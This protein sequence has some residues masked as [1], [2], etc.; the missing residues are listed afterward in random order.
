MDQRNKTSELSDL[1]AAFLDEHGYIIL[2]NMLNPDEL[3]ALR[4]R[5]DEVLRI[6]GLSAGDV[7]Q[8][9]FQ[10]QLRQ[11]DDALSRVKL[12]LYNA[13]FF[14]VKKMS[15]SFFRFLPGLAEH[16]K[17]V[18]APGFK[19]PPGFSIKREI[20]QMLATQAQQDISGTIRICDL[21]NKGAEFDVLYTHPK[22]IAAVRHIIGKNFKLS[23]LNYRSP[24]PQQGQQL[25]HVDWGWATRPGEYFACNALWLLDDLTLENG[26]TRIVAGSHLYGILPGDEMDNPMLPHPDQFLPSPCAG[27]ILLVN[28]HVW[29]G[30]TLN[31]SSKPRRLIQSYFVHKAHPAQLEQRQFLKPETQ[32]RLSKQA[33]AIL[34][35]PLREEN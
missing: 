35:I 25:L 19:T 11:S 26:A 18:N 14:G 32:K 30:G 3:S 16:V 20:K 34:D 17:K 13:L 29:H 2:E 22:L 28:S 1:E 4:A 21:V 6:E 31:N 23:S 27:S 5:T 24:K 33:L 8:T 7:G 9:L 10:Q 12:A 15:G